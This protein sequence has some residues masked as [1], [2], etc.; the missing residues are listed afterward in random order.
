M[1]LPEAVKLPGHFSLLLSLTEDETSSVCLIPNAKL[2]PVGKT[3]NRPDADGRQLFS[4]PEGGGSVELSAREL[5]KAEGLYR[6]I[7]QSFAAGK[8]SL[9]ED[10]FTAL[11]LARDVYEDVDGERTFM[12]VRY[13]RCALVPLGKNRWQLLLRAPGTPGRIQEGTFENMDCF[14][15]D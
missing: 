12:A 15:E 8:L 13:E 14:E 9:L 11:V 1:K 4:L 5:Q 3:E 2:M 10:A 6:F 7:H